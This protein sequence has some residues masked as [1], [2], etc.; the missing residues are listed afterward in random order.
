MN[1]LNPE[2]TRLRIQDSEIRELR[3]K[4]EKLEQK[5]KDIRIGIKNI[6]LSFAANL[7][8]SQKIKIIEIANEL[9][10]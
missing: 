4:N 3:E 5:I 10:E 7:P 8:Y 9:D 1:M 2:Q 6:F